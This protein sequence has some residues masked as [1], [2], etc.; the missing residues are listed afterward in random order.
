MCFYHSRYA[1]L[2][3]A[4]V[5]AASAGTPAAG[6]DVV[7]YCSTWWNTPQMWGILGGAASARL[8]KENTPL[9]L[10]GPCRRR[11]A[12][13]R[14][15]VSDCGGCGP[16]P[17]GR[18]DTDGRRPAPLDRRRMAGVAPLAVHSAGLGGRDGRRGPSDY[19]PAGRPATPP[20][21]GPQR[22]AG[23]RA[24][25]PGWAGRCWGG[26]QDS[27]AV[28]PRRAARGLPSGGSARL[29]TA[30]VDDC[31]RCLCWRAP[32]WYRPQ[33]AAAVVRTPV[34]GSVIARQTSTS[35]CRP[36]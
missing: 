23:H 5:A 6:V 12:W 31:R 21:H 32:G 9:R 14:G 28:V 3:A 22:S 36:Y 8:L 13:Q 25:D 19:L 30:P 16:G 18:T 33:R 34:S 20:G 17:A 27:S 35:C 29:E 15:A 7:E 26:R 11:L 10:G 24:S 2:A 4:V 1:A